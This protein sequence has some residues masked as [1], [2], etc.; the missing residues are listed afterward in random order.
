MVLPGSPTGRDTDR[1][2][3][4]EEIAKHLGR[5]VRT[6]QRYERDSGLPVHRTS[7]KDRGAVVASRAEIQQ[8]VMS[9]PPRAELSLRTASPELATS[10][11]PIMDSLR[12]MH[13]LDKQ[14]RTLQKKMTESLAQVSKT[15]RRARTRAAQT[16][17]PA[18]LKRSA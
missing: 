7:G 8:W 2:T 5:G 17:A 1:L 13:D 12:K 15:I 16:P 18:R 6:V 14:S 10:E 11:A 4:W 3:G 9:H